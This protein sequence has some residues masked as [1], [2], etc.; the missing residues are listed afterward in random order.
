MLNFILIADQQ[1]LTPS[2]YRGE[3]LEEWEE[4]LEEGR[5]VECLLDRVKSHFKKTGPK[6]SLQQIEQQKAQLIKDLPVGSEVHDSLLNAA[7]SMSLVENVSLLSHAK[8]TN[9]IAVNMY[10]DDEGSIKNLPLN[11]RA[12]EISQV[13]GKPLQVRG[14]AFLSRVFDDGNDF[15]RL[16]FTVAEVSSGAKWLQDA[17][18][19]NARLR[20]AEAAGSSTRIMQEIQDKGGM[21]KEVAPA[22]TAKDQGNEYFRKGEW[23]EAIQ[24]YSM[25]IQLNP[26]LI[27]A[28]NNRAMASLKLQKYEDAIIDCTTVLNTQPHNVKAL[29][30]RAAA[31]RALKDEIHE[32][33]DLAR[34]LE[35]EPQN[36][37]ARTRY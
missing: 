28:I 37:E 27:S 30:R 36:K 32:K 31:H 5:E 15:D 10:V 23:D 13:A 19:Q 8:D 14:D 12:S 4:T 21:R 29:L 24:A 26:D 35:I 17:R 22:E 2:L 20:A 33:E 11:I 9:F 18:E 34:V 1:Q 16:N 3:P 7:T 25:A 6:K